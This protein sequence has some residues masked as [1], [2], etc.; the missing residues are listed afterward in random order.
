MLCI[1]AVAVWNGRKYR[2]LLLQR[3]CVYI[4]QRR[5]A[6][7]AFHLYSQIVRSMRCRDILILTDDVVYDSIF[8]FL[9]KKIAVF[10][11]KSKRANAGCNIRR[12]GPE[13]YSNHFTLLGVGKACKRFVYFR[14]G[15]QQRSVRV[16]LDSLSSLR[17]PPPP[18][19]LLFSVSSS[20]F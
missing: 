14:K 20:S 8:L 7:T 10:V 5:S 11:G 3:V 19:L 13:G 2:K 1:H 9:K 15:T 6:F 17:P 12:I 18:H 16:G 4:Y